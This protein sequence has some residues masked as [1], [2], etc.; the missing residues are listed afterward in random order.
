MGTKKPAANEPTKAGSAKPQKS[1]SAPTTPKKRPLPKK[2]DTGNVSDQVATGKSELKTD[3]KSTKK[4]CIKTGSVKQVK[5]NKNES[6]DQKV[7]DKEK[8]SSSTSNKPNNTKSTSTKPKQTG[9]NAKPPQKTRKDSSSERTKL[10]NELKNLGIEVLQDGPKGFG[11][12]Q[13]A[14]ASS[15][16]KISICEKVKTKSRASVSPAN[17]VPFKVTKSKPV[18]N[19]KN[20]SKSSENKPTEVETVDSQNKAPETSSTSHVETKNDE[21][22]KKSKESKETDKIKTK[23]T[24]DKNTNEE[25][26]GKKSKGTTPKKVSTPKK[27]ETKSTDSNKNEKP[28]SGSE[29]KIENKPDKP[30]SPEE[31][32]S[33]NGNQVSS[34]DTTEK[35][36]KIFK[37]N[38]KL[39]PKPLSQSSVSLVKR[40]YQKKNV[41][42]GFVKPKAKVLKATETKKETVEGMGGKPKDIY[43]FHESGSGS[44]PLSPIPVKDP[45]E[46]LVNKKA[47]IYKRKLK[48][49]SES[50]DEPED[51]SHETDDKND[52]KTNK[53][54]E[55]D[56]LKPTQKSE[57]TGTSTP[58]KPKNEKDES[59]DDETDSDD[60]D[61]TPIASQIKPGT[62]YIEKKKVLAKKKALQ[63]KKKLALKKKAAAAR[64][65]QKSKPSFEESEDDDE[66]DSSMD[67]MITR[68]QHRRVAKTR[69]LK[70]YGFWSGP[71]RHREASLNALAKVHCLYENETRSALEQDLIKAAKLESL[72]DMQKVQKQTTQKEATKSE[73]NSSAESEEPGDDDDEEEEKEE[74]NKRYLQLFKIVSKLRL[75]TA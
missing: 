32:G 67:S 66:S 50:K 40:K 58:V 16:C 27:S 5:T 60:S 51:I 33:E 57:S 75:I 6:K 47:P 23:E 34:K 21:Q 25:N 18:N 36:T 38:K 41:Q 4:K 44:E 52:I 59:N 13:T 71:K 69:H 2:K 28:K 62:K 65:Q 14:A 24:P 15:D 56:E 70:K 26:S 43:D 31:T 1:D 53:S 61:S 48:D 12:K 64:K 55:N 22:I 46:L 10:S 7:T 63:Q 37:S 3:E 11:L 68:I 8:A 54:A 73:N 9:K 17:Y 39:L 49:R 20:E 74:D 35:K 19:N 42:P 72:K 30:E 45:L 29:T